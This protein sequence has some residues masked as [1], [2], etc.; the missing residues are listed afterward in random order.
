[1]TNKIARDFF[2]AIKEELIKYP[3]QY[4]MAG[5]VLWGVVMLS[6][7]LNLDRA[8]LAIVYLIIAHAL[9]SLMLYIGFVKSVKGK[10]APLAAAVGVLAVLLTLMIDTLFVISL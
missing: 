1:M 5:F 3:N 10:R 2:T 7:S 4:A 8:W 9:A 6:F